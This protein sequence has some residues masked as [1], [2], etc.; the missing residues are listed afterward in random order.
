MITK[1]SPEVTKIK[2]Q[3]FGSRVY[4]IKL[5]DQNILIDISSKENAD[6]LISSLSTLNLKSED[7][8][9]IILTHAHWDH[10]E[11]INLFPN[12]KV[13]GNFTKTINRD[14]S[15]TEL[16]NIHPIEKLNIPEFKIHKTPGHTTGDILILYKDILFSGDV[17]FHNNYIGRTDFPESVPEK[18][19]E[20]L[21]FIKTLK[22]D[23][24]CPG[25]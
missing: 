11:N 13:Y 22:Y 12:T 8:T 24:L 14:H 17:I 16:K 7:I 6:E 20:T 18:M 21:K 3:H 2:M 25:H 15:Q 1:I 23:I 9:T 4:L 5:P 19:K 10:V